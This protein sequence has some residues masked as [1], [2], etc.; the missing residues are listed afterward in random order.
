MSDNQPKQSETTRKPGTPPP[1][2]EH[3]ID[4]LWC[5]QRGGWCKKDVDQMDREL[6][7]HLNGQ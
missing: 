5:I 4:P 3:C 1:C 6:E 2:R 7:E